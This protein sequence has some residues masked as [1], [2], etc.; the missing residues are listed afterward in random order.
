MHILVLGGSG[1]N[2]T[3]VIQEAL[4][5]GHSI[6]AMVR[7]PTGF[8]LE[9][10]P[11]LTVITGEAYLHSEAPSKFAQTRANLGTSG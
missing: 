2:G 10:H 1:Q 8:R 5:R 11:Q 4:A 3:L 9:S 6:T 7:S